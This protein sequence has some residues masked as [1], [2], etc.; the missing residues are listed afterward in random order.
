MLSKTECTQSAWDRIGG[1]DERA[2]DKQDNHP[3]QGVNWDSVTAW[4]QKVGDL[5]LPGE[6]ELTCATRTGMSWRQ[7]FAEVKER[8]LARARRSDD[9]FVT[10]DRTAPVMSSL[11][12]PWG[13]H[14]LNGSVHE[15]CRDVH[16][17][18][19]G[20]RLYRMGTRLVYP[21]MTREEAPHDPFG[22]EM[23]FGLRPAADLPR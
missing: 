11:P 3:I 10:S 22:A 13:L 7:Y 1:D 21:W 15:W 16:I 12:N 20:T 23:R 6:D 9:P 19:S 18:P 4:C 14:D 5:R 17:Y 2:W 8:S